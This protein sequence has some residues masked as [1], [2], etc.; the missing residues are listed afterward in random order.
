MP[1]TARIKLGDRD[2]NL[3]T[4]QII[5]KRAAMIVSGEDTLHEISPGEARWSIDNPGNNWWFSWD[6]QSATISISTRYAGDDIVIAVKTLII[7]SEPK[8][9]ADTKPSYQTGRVLSTGD[10]KLFQTEEVA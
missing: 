5:A 6:Q 4:V 3:D 2:N 8:H 10:L 7:N 9:P 1:I